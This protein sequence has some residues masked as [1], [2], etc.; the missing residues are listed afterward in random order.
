MTLDPSIFSNG[1]HAIYVSPQGHLSAPPPQ[2]L[3]ATNPPLA[4][5]APTLKRYNC[6][7]CTQFFNSRK[8][9][10][11]PVEHAHKA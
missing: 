1:S 3:P 2:A 6:A 11:E 4:L 5:P 9:L 7:D 8:H 10:N